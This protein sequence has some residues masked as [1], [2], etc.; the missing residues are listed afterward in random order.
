MDR[1]TIID[2]ATLDPSDLGPTPTMIG[3]AALAAV[4]A[5]IWWEVTRRS[6]ETK[7][8]E[9]GRGSWTGIGKIATALGIATVVAFAATLTI[10]TGR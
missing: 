7:E 3:L 10:A 5:L 2:I 1:T 4:S 8:R 9:I 6:G